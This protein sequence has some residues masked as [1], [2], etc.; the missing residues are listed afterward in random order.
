MNESNIKMMNYC[1]TKQ[2]HPNA[3]A[4]SQQIRNTYNK[5]MCFE[6]FIVNKLRIKSDPQYFIDKL[7]DVKCGYNKDPMETHDRF[8]HIINKYM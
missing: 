3:V 4:N 1:K 2:V 7:H 6:S 5:T 8:L